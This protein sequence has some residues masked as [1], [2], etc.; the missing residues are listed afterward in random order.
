MDPVI[1][2]PHRQYAHCE[3]GVVAALLTHYGLAISEP[4]VF[5][6]SGGLTF[7]YI[8]FIKITNLPIISYRMFPHAIIQGIQK[9]LGIRFRTRTYR[10]RKRPGDL[11]A[12]CP[13]AG[14]SDF[15]RPCTGSPTSPTRC[16]S[17]S[18]PTT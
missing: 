2:F 14:W 15:R 5:G 7:A 11:V 18:T 13:K 10:T 12:P 16:G 3:S 17:S 9:R 4:L 6:I 8:P 1:P